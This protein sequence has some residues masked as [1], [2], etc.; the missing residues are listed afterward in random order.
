MEFDIKG[1][2]RERLDEAAKLYITDLTALPDDALGTVMGGV[3]RTVYDFTFECVN[4]N[5]RMAASIMGSPLPRP[6]D[7]EFKA[8]AGQMDTKQ[9]AID[10]I[11]SSTNAL[12]DAWMALDDINK[13]IP[14]FGGTR[15]CIDMV[16]LCAGHMMYHD[17]QINFIQ[18]LRGDGEV[19]WM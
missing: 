8:M 16:S 6:S 9:K 12:I 14:A 3:A 1:H 13:E 4:V 11:R 2:L 5:T 15:K 7:D 10:G 19:H 17:G 18:A